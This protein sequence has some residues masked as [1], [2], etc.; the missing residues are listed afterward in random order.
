MKKCKVK[1]RGRLFFVW[2][3]RPLLKIISSIK[4]KLIRK[5]TQDLGKQ[6]EQDIQDA[7][8]DEDILDNVKGMV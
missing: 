7:L 3:Q 5:L 2:T 1:L 4:S 6:Y 8:E